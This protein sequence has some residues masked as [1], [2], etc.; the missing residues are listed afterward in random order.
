MPRITKRMVDEAKPQSKD[1]FAWDTDLPGFGLKVT[2]KGRKVFVIQ[3]R[4]GGRK[5][6]TR[7]YTIGA[8]GPLTIE[9]SRSEAKRLLGEVA[10]GRDP[11]EQ[12]KTGQSVPGLHDLLDDFLAEHVDAKLKT[13]TATE[14]RRVVS[15][16][17]KPR[18]K[19]RPIDSIQRAD[20]ARMHHAMQ[21][22]P[23]QA[24]RALALLSKFFNWCEKRGYR[25]DGSNPCR[26]IEKYKE[27][28]RE[29]FLS[30]DE[31]RRLGAVLV[32]AETDGIIVDAD[33]ALVWKPSPHVVAA[34]RLLL[35]TGA[36]LSEILSLK[37]EYVDFE[38][39][40]IRLPDSKTG[41]KTIFLNAPTLEV[42]ANITRLEKNPYVI[43][44][45]KEGAH[46]INLQKPWRRIRA[47]ADLHNVRIH[48]LRHS[49]ASIAA[50][51][52][53]SLPM[54]GAL[55][56][57]SQPQTTA[58]YA[59]L[60]ENPVQAA[61]ERIAATIEGAINGSGRQVSRLRK[62]PL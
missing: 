34:V 62:T 18:L 9:Q 22:G 48:D 33:K 12:K 2:P 26:H 10:A 11:Q 19:N 35:L 8:Y 47:A 17:I 24:N 38:K 54:I 23:Y 56:G 42:L 60:A 53:M 21:S 6:V 5:G 36:R 20:V 7:R 44:G 4:L 59:H 55:L 41:A 30:P 43:C 14:Y 49:F 52:G 32:V 50:G 51:A 61:S 15:V 31:I 40:R 58:R 16:H 13:S 37:W 28:K 39:A 3:Y 45:E 46:L 29:R 27:E 57:H 1:T 25:P